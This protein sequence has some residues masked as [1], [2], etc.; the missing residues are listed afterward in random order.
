MREI[1]SVFGIEE[2]P[3]TTVPITVPEHLVSN[4]ERIARPDLTY[5]CSISPLCQDTTP[6]SLFWLH[7][8][9]KAWLTFLLNGSANKASSKCT[10]L[11][12]STCMINT[13]F[14]YTVIETEKYAHVTFFFNGGVEDKFKKEDRFLIDSPKVATYDLQPEMSVLSVASKVAEIV[15]TKDYEFVMCNFAPP[16]MVGHTG[17]YD[18]AVKA[19]SYT[20][21]A[22][23]TV[24]EA[25]KE[26]GYVLLITADHGNAEQMINPETGN[27]HTA[28]ATNPVPFIMTADPNEYSFGK[29]AE[30]E[31]EGALCDVA[32][33][34]LD[35][36]GLEKP[37]G[38]L[39]SIK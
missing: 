19:I 35:L 14:S 9:L 16:D 17:K 24:Y 20:D 5:I 7:S 11:V 32:P 21:K 33:T 38:T 31:E 4:D 27:P 29:D 15:K 23:K 2:K 10:S 22:V 39:I 12:S 30:D 25:C 37:H 8:H 26:A 3:N 13:L 36:M 34:I 28:H 1:V 6:N 18:A